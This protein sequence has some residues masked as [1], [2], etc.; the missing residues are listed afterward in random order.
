MVI[1]FPRF[2]G[3]SAILAGI[4]G[5]LYSL[6]FIVITPAAPVLGGLLSALFLLLGGLLSTAALVAVYSRLRKIEAAFALWALLLALAGALGSAVH[7]GYDLANSINPPVSAPPGLA[8]LPSQIDPRG[9]LTFGVTGI[10]LFVIAWLMGRDGGF[11]R[12]LSYLGY[13]LAILLV[14]L[15]LGRLIVLQASSPVIIVP[16]LLAGF[17]VNPLWYIWLGIALWREQR[18]G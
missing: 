5:F 2:A 12:G 8:D 13:L 15:Y 3:P 16:A 17:L 6:A 18:E 7:G 10:G 14:I 9:L 4:I 1:S 11:P